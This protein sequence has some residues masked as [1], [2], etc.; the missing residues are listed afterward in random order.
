MNQSVVLIDRD[1]KIQ[2]AMHHIKFGYFRSACPVSFI[3]PLC[4]D[5]D[6]E[7]RSLSHGNPTRKILPACIRHPYPMNNFEPIAVEKNSFLGTRNN[8]SSGP[9]KK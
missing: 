5:I 7:H 1:P 2:H 3:I 6:D 8:S 9:T 4:E